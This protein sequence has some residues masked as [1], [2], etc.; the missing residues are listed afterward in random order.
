MNRI[1]LEV[2]MLRKGKTNRDM[3]KE[4]GID[5]TTWYRKKKGLFRYSREDIIAICHVLGICAN[6]MIE[7]FF[8]DL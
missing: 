1:E 7:I 2:E 4:T 6:R 5:Y 8:D 3:V